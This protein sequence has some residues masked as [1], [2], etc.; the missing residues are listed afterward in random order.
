MAF[1]T[2][3]GNKKTKEL[4]NTIIKQNKF[5]HSYMFVG[6]SGI[7][8]MLYAKEFSKRA[9]CLNREEICNKCKS[10]LEFDNN[11]HPDFFV[12]EPDGNSIKIEQ[13]RELT[14]KIIEKPIVSEKK[15]YI[16]NNAYLMTREAQNCLLKTLEEPPEFAIIILIVEN[17]GN[18]L[19]TIKSRCT[20][21][22]FE[23][24]SDIE[25]KKLLE[26]KYGT[27]NLSDNML[28]SFNGSMEK[29]TKIMENKEFYNK[30]ENIF[31]NIEKTSRIS[32]LNNDE[33]YKNKEN[34]DEIL[35]YIN[36]IFWNKL[37]ENHKYINCLNI[38]QEAR[39]RLA[40]NANF[41]MTI[42]NML[43]KIWE[44]IT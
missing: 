5:L 39:N 42:D 17:E 12:I 38:V 7:G 19:N 34:I 24:I 23:N 4:L 15:I 11:N 10:C 37:Q 30:I 2:L 16:I 3:A 14:N 41:D 8:K 35:D 27:L 9:M 1:E 22:Y 40:R 36:I 43:I 25:M 6:Q 33:I 20:K 28:K 29:A 21:I 31:S 26:K 32:L 13:I 44:E 18:I